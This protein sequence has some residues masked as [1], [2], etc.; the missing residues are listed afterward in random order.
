VFLLTSWVSAQDFITTKNA[1]GP[2]KC[3]GV[4]KLNATKVKMKDWYWQDA[5]TKFLQKSGEMLDSLCAGKYNFIFTDSLGHQ[6]T[7]PFTINA[8]QPV[9]KCDGFS[10][11]I[12]QT[13]NNT[14]K[15]PNC[16][17]M[18]TVGVLGGTAPYTFTWVNANNATAQ[19]LDGLCGGKYYVTV[20]DANNCSTSTF[21]T[22]TN[23][24]DTT[25]TNKCDG[26][27]VEV[28]GFGNNKQGAANCIG[29]IETKLTG[30]V[31]PFAFSWTNGAKEPYIKGLCAGKF[32]LTVKDSNG[33]VATLS[34][35]IATDS[36][37]TGVNPCAGFKIEFVK[38]A[39]DKASDTICTG[40]IVARAVGGVEP[41]TF[42]WNTGAKTPYLEN[43]CAGV[44]S[45]TAKDAN[46]CYAAFKYEIKAEQVVTTN[47]CDGFKIELV[48]SVND[49]AGDTICTGAAVVN[50]VGGTAPFT[51]LWSNGAKG[52]YNERLCA[53]TY[54]AYAIDAKNCKTYVAV[55]IK[56]D[57]TTTTKKN[58][59]SF[60]TNL[61]G[62]KNTLKGG[63]A[64][65][66]YLAA[67]I[68]GGQQP[69]TYYWSTGS[70]D[71]AIKMLCAG[72][73]T[74]KAIDA[75]GCISSFVSEI[76]EEVAMDSNKCAGFAANIIVKNAQAGT[77]ECNGAMYASVSGGKEPYTYAWT[78]NK[79]DK[80]ITGLCAGVYGVKVTDA[81]GCTVKL[82][83]YVGKDSIV[84]N[85][86][87]GLFANVYVLNA[88]KGISPCTGAL[89]ANVGGG[90]APYKFKWSDGSSLSALKS[91]CE[92]S[93]TLTVMDSANCSLTIEKYVGLDSVVNPCANFYA[94]ISGV[95]NCGLNATVC[96]GSLATTVVGGKAP[97]DFSWNTGAKSPSITNLCAGE[98]SVEV[99]DANKCH[100]TLE[101][102]V[103]IDSAK[104]ACAGFYTKVVS[105]LNDK[106]GDKE[107]S[108]EIKTETVGGTAP[109]AFYW[110]NGNQT[111]TASKLCAGNYYLYV[112]DKNGCIN[113]LEKM[114]GS[115]SIV[116]NCKGFFAYVANAVDFSEDDANC[117]GKLEVA[118]KGGK[119]P[120]TYTWSNGAT[121]NVVTDLCAD[122]Y[123]VLVKDAN[124][125]EVKLGAKIVKLPSKNATLKAKVHTADATSATACDGAMKIEVE[126]G[127]TPYAFYHSN[128]EVGQ[129]RTGVCPGV[130]SVIVKDAKGQ[131]LELKYLI[132]APTNVIENKN[133]SLKGK[134][135]ADTVKSTITKECAIN[136]NAIDSVK[137][138]NKVYKN[139]T[140]VVTWAVYNANTV[141]YVTDAYV[142]T[143]GKGVYKIKL[144]LYCDEVKQIGNYVTVTE[145]VLYELQGQT[146]ASVNELTS[147]N[148]IVYPN[149]F[150][151][152]VSISLDKVQDYKVQV[153]DMAG[154]EIYTN[155]YANTNAITLNLAHL[156]SGQY[157]VK[158][159]S[160]T[161]S[162]T[163]MIAK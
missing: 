35:E 3:D 162:F 45:L 154:K 60:I 139:D 54:N 36:A 152:K 163:R 145:N 85:P 160:E 151:D 147:L 89:V 66:G 53:G 67:G 114:V 78:N 161:A 119:A 120:F 95:E 158:I 137:I 97:Y 76:K 102:K 39:N 65:N 121:T 43:I 30:G 70:K 69:Y 122:G 64:C 143:K 17:G 27:K 87:A 136:F 110:S 29:F 14:G 72:S 126:G 10:A 16:N 84:Q 22:I 50:A 146:S 52:N 90:K 62:M 107:C 113:K 40:G 92:G 86:C 31:K 115:D 148:A 48:K 61:V 32:G 103:Y 1:T 37:S 58:C 105:V 123:S 47:V 20:K 55:T 7:I 100:I 25:V 130:Y 74:F 138:A 4:A 81:N 124:N 117:A 111:A 6:N 33:C 38:A 12:K 18:L 56:A 19:T 104:N 153:I 134:P 132:S 116:D 129:Y 109:Y 82:D 98:Y 150:T 26:F 149:P 77:K 11:L 24:S 59:A 159:V 63:I 71:L 75:N 41:F 144:D 46:N 8:D 94:K 9:N 135:V 23:S 28:V 131:Y 44:Y 51:Y 112:K 118:V 140:L 125:C 155:S 49:Q 96:N 142:F 57:T 34:K 79:A 99:V 157:L 73:Y 13:V 128:G 141:V 68:I 101:G 15:A 83:K 106:A 127:T 42:E 108:G 133:D 156:T 80:Y 5:S 21:G 93:Y 91:V 2:D 88:K